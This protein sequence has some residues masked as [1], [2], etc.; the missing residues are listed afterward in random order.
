MPKVSVIIPAYNHARF[1]GEA[2]GSV[3]AQSFQDFELIVVDDGS[4]DNTKE[5][6]ASFQ[7]N[8]VRYIHQQNRGVAAAQNVGVRNS[9]GEYVAILGADDVW[10]PRKLELQVE[11]LD[12]R[13]EIALVC[14]D[15]YIFDDRTG[16]VLGRF[17]HNEPFG[18]RVNAEKAS[19]RPLTEMLSRGC[20]IAPQVAM[21]R[22]WVFN[23]VGCFDESLRAYEDW[24]MFVRIV[25][26]FAI[27]TIDMPLAKN[28]KHGGNMSGDWRQMG[29]AAEIVYN[30]ALEKYSLQP[31]DRRI[32]RRR[33]AR[34]RS[35]Y[36]RH[37]I[38]DGEKALGR[39]KLLSS[40][41]LYPWRLRPY[42]WLAG[43]F[44]KS[45][46]VLNLGS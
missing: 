38:V 45:K 26:R 17:W 12:S 35:D 30:K 22:R 23:E 5:V 43:S 7:D 40:I 21:V 44:L 15:F 46:F 4:I 1:L 33:L 8:R 16:A 29:E 9:S 39:R 20:F 31:D 24:D 27:G 11:L 3:L 34:R 13:P 36:G 37:L 41:K 10:L 32:V 28:R 42:V 19:R 25:Q 18:Y 6:A 14:S 2:I